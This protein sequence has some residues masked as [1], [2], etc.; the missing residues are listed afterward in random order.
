MEIITIE[1]K[2]FKSLVDKI[3]ILTD[4]ILKRQVSDKN[5]EDIWLDSQEVADLLRIS[6]RTLQRLRTEDA[7]SYHKLR[8]RCLYKLSEIEDKFNNRVIKSDPNY[9][10]IEKVALS[11]LQQGI[12][13]KIISISTKLPIQE[14]NKMKQRIK[15]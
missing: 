11:L 2:A 9:T 5:K 14:I 6:T 13:E 3:E 7:I 15:G 1:S 8:G 12:D 10:E 4:Y